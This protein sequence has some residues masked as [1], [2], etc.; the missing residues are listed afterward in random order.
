MTRGNYVQIATT[1][2]MFVINSW[3][4]YEATNLALSLAMPMAFMKFSRSFESEADYLGLQYMY[5]AGL[6]PAGLRL[7]LREN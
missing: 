3:G 4:V 2:L 1:P 6:R 7:V 5:K